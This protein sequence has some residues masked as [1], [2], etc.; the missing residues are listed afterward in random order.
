MK[1]ED[2]LEDQQALNLE[3]ALVRTQTLR[4]TRSVIPLTPKAIFDLVHGQL[5]IKEETQTRGKRT[6]GHRRVT[7]PNRRNT[8]KVEKI[9]E[10]SVAK[11]LA[12]F[13]PSSSSR[14]QRSGPP[15]SR[16]LNPSVIQTPSKPQLVARSPKCPVYCSAKSTICQPSLRW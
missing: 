12:Q 9:P 5:K 8:E 3:G 11:P 6:E 14:P 1:C 2:E 7:N 15:A 4:V 13:R 10:T 16:Q